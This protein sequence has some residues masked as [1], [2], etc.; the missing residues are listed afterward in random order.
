[1]SPPEAV[2]G[3]RNI[4]LGIGI[5]VMPPV[6]GSP[7]QRRSGP[8]KYREESEYRRHP[9]VEPQGAMRDRAMV[10]DSGRHP[11]Y[12]DQ[13]KRTQQDP[14]ARPRKQDQADQ[15][16]DVN[17]HKPWKHERVMVAHA[18]PRP[19]PR[20]DRQPLESLCAIQLISPADAA[21]IAVWNNSMHMMRHSLGPLAGER[22]NKKPK[23]RGRLS[24]RRSDR[25][26]VVYAG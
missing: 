9:R 12:P 22:A 19:L 20:R 7:T 15:R 1:M 3:A 17:Q 13:A 23:R 14:P 16:G 8:I 2:D 24:E 6:T 18:P 10:A 21:E 11:A 26:A 4:I 5:S 25:W